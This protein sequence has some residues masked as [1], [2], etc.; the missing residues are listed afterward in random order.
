MITPIIEKAILNGYGTLH[1]YSCT[2][3]LAK[4]SIPKGHFGIITDFEYFPYSTHNE[5]DPTD[6]EVLM[7]QMGLDNFQEIDFYVRNKSH[8]WTFKVN[9]QLSTISLG[10]IQRTIISPSSHHHVDTMIFCDEDIYIQF[11]YHL[12]LNAGGVMS[13][14]TVPF[15][16]APTTDTVGQTIPTLQSITTSTGRRIYPTGFPDTGQQPA[17][18]DTQFCFSPDQTYYPGGPIDYTMNLPL[19]NVQILIVPEQNRNNL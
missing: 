5:L 16:Q 8:K 2:G 12:L 13:Y 15:T 4:I 1:N 17:G 18:F 3:G 10:S 6:Y 19:V 14:L 7:N 9:Y 11:K